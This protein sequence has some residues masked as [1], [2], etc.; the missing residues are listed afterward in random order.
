MSALRVRAAAAVEAGVDPARLVLDP[1]IGF[2][3]RLEHNLA[4]LRRLPELRSLGQPLLLGVSRKSFIGHVTG[5][6]RQGDWRA[7]ERTDRPDE[8]LGGTAAAVAAC[9]SGGA[10][11]LRVHDVWVMREAI[12]VA[13]A[14]AG[15]RGRA[16]S[17]PAG[18]P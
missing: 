5:A 7:P 1:G 17:T 13:A 15:A 14:L 10:E 2:G 16:G 6:E 3:K 18:R 11:L 9:V 12:E 4:L 8:R